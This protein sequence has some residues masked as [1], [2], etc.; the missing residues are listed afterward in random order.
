MMFPPA[1][2]PAAARHV[3]A[4]RVCQIADPSQIG[5]VRRR[6][7]EMTRQAGMDSTT[8]S[9]IA[10]IVTE[11]ATN[12]LNHAVRGT[13]AL[14]ILPEIG[15][16]L[17]ILAIDG[18]PGMADVER[19]VADGY[20]T[21]GTKG[22]GLGAVRRLSD[23]FDVWSDATGTVVMSRVGC[24]NVEG[25]A[26]GCL[27]IPKRGEEQCGDAWSIRHGSDLDAL[28]VVDGLGHGPDA[29]IVALAAVAAFRGSS[30]SDAKAMLEHIDVAIRGSRGAAVA[31]VMIPG[32]GAPISY[33]GIGNIGARLESVGKSRGLVSSNGI[34]GGNF[35]SPQKFE[36]AV[37]GGELLV[38]HSD[39]L[40]YHWDLDRYSGLRFRHPALIAAILFRDFSRDRDDVTVVVVRLDAP[41]P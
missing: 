3:A 35:R 39:G 17:E 6:A 27:T 37:V 40:K 19:C 38:L 7:D 12:I 1:N 20:S 23:Q 24:R 28:L 41:K 34:V 10:I 21:S 9:N 15:E 25:L 2:Q 13:I 4:Q 31:V 8:C 5:E 26:L 32:G 16:G 18:G 14:R 11:L 22:N 30:L 29:E 36:Y 33:C